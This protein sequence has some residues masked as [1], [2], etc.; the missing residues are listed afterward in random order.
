MFNE[1]CIS[2]TLYNLF[3]LQSFFYT[4][5]EEVS[6]SE[7]LKKNKRVKEEKKERKEKRKEKKI[8]KRYFLKGFPPPPVAPNHESTTYKAIIFYSH[9]KLPFTIPTLRYIILPMFYT[10]RYGLSP[11]EVL[12]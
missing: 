2:I 7:N 5:K 10:D 11:T 8:K 3:S 12:P 1:T 6:T 4:V 9:L